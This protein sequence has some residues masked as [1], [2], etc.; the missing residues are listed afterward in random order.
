MDAG[1]MVLEGIVVFIVVGGFLVSIAPAIIL[2]IIWIIR[3]KLGKSP[4]FGPLG[5]ISIIVSALTLMGLPYEFILLIELVN[6][7]R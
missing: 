5:I 2:D 4:K 6:F 7:V 1:M 3:V